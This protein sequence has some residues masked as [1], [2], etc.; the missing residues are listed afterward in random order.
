MRYC[1]A[2]SG[3]HRDLLRPGF[4][5][6]P[7]DEVAKHRFRWAINGFESH[8]GAALTD[9]ADPWRECRRRAARKTERGDAQKSGTPKRINDT[10]C[11]RITPD[12]TPPHRQSLSPRPFDDPVLMPERSVAP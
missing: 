12:R 6:E 1:A 3:H 8:R 10:P 7:E 9:V 4:L 5:V 2:D 11:R